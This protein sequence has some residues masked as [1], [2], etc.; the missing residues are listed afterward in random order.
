MG[1]E[2]NKTDVAGKKADGEIENIEK[3]EIAKDIVDE[4][5]LKIIGAEITEEMKKAY[6]DY[7]MS[8]IVARALPSVEDGLKPVQRRIL[9]AM[10]KMGL[11]PGKPTRKSARIVGEVLGKFHPHGDTAV[12]DTLV[13]MAQDFSLRYPLIKGQ[14]NFGSL[15][16]DSPAAMRYTEAKLATISLELIQDIDKET[17]KMLP[18]FDNSLKEPETLPGKLPN[19]LINGA[20]GIAVGMA[21]NIPPH[22]LI[23]VCDAIIKYLENPNVS[24]EKLARIIKGPD[25]PTGGYVSGDM[26]GIYR[27]GRGRLV[28]R[29]KTITEEKKGK[30]KIVITEVP[31]MLNKA[32]LVS[33]IAKFVQAKKL[34][35]ISDI[36]DESSKGKVR[37][38]IEL[39][40]GADYKF[41]LNRLY[42]YTRLQDNFDVN[43]IAL[44]G[45]HPKS[46]NLKQIIE[47]YVKYREKI[48]ERRTKFDLKKAR[49]RLEIV[50]GLLIALRDIDAVVKLIK[51]S[52]HTTEAQAGLIKKFKLTMKQA[53]AILDMKLSSLTSLEQ[54]KLKKEEKE[55]KR[56]IKELEKILSSRKEILG[57]IRKEILELR[58]KYGDARRTYILQRV[59]EISEKDLVQ[60]KQVVITIT[61]KGYVK[62]LDLKTYKEQKRGGSGVI[63]SSLATGDFVKHTITCSTHDYLLFF[64]NKGKVYWLK[65]YEIP[66]SARYSRGKAIINML[67][68]RDEKI[69][70]VISVEKF[71]DYLIMATKK[72][73]IKRLPLKNL[74][75][76]RSTGVKAINLPAD[77]SDNLISVK[78]IKEGQEIILA[79]KNGFAIRFN[80]REV[81][82]MGRAAYGVTGI[83]LHSGDQVVSLEVLPQDEKTTILSITEKG[84]GKRSD[85]NNYRLTARAGKGIIN[86]RVTERTGRVVN[87]CSV[88]D[89]DSII[90]TT[91]KGMVIRTGVRQLR[92]MGRA[93]Q[94]VKIVRLHIGDKVTDMVKV[95]NEGN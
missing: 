75:H 44:V 56:T 86:L 77:G 76:P 60:K 67:N 80:S 16:G 15:D 23:E 37:I 71:E 13:R 20:T 55:L 32:D 59:S 29:G 62:R 92:V 27:T 18:N 68:L 42:K 4:K 30:I 3:K 8:V 28:L 34:P 87:T 89:S 19:L 90:V 41:T 91:Q 21:T 79:T 69:A 10:S 65:A 43:I 85:I 11:S 6:I 26:I 31:Y 36:R 35:D 73:I 38:V 94:G 9:Y 52:R 45:G 17:V 47:E 54:D 39:R 93:T 78:E 50:L 49:E 53:Q 46:L 74:S 88:V 40:R 12:Y 72:G 7:A 63:G 83:K 2:K 61:D 84:Y 58:R 82:A 57:V 33:Q 5:G 14:G 22:N 64:T 1:K 24:V 25:F 70:S 66:D 51:S 81:R 95:V 48:I